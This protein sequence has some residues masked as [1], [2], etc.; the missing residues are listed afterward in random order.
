MRL[1]LYNGEVKNRKHIDD[2]IGAKKRIQ[3][4][5]NEAVWLVAEEA[6]NRGLLRTVPPS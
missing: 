6:M 2:D 1:I 3:Q 4:L 5:Y